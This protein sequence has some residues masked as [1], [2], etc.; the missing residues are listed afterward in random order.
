MITMLIILNI[1]LIM[2]VTIRQAL[3]FS[4][5]TAIKEIKYVSAM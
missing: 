3:Q 2:K 4:L 5:A 1:T